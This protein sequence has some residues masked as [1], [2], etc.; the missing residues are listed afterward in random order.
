MKILRQRLGKPLLT[1]A[2]IGVLAGAAW[3]SWGL[4]KT[5]P[6]AQR[7]RIKVQAPL[8]SVAPLHRTDEPVSIAAHGTVMAARE[9]TLRSEVRGR[10]IEAH[11]QLVPGGLIRK[12]EV[13]VRIDPSDFEIAERRAKAAAAE[14]EVEWQIEQ[15]R[16]IVAQRE[17]ELLKGEDSDPGESSLALRKPQ[18]QKVEAA[19]EK[20]KADL[21]DAKL[22]LSRTVVRAPFDAVVIRE[23]V[24]TGQLIE[25]QTAI[26]ELAGTDEFW[27]EAL[28]PVGRLERI[29]IPGPEAEQQGAAVELQL[30]TGATPVVRSGTV[31]RQLAGLDPNGRMA[32]VVISVDDPLNLQGNARL[33]RLPLGSYVSL[34]I[35]AGV[36]E[37]I[38]A[39]P[40][41]ALRENN[42][43]WTVDQEKRLHIRPV[44]V[45][46]RRNDDV[47]VRTAFPT[48]E[49]AITSHLSSVIPGMP[50]RIAPSQPILTDRESEERKQV[51]AKT[52]QERGKP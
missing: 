25:T 1:L 10:V 39:V 47:L 31:C 26:A 50:V 52:L 23:S 14:A 45:I 48:G 43:V 41:F 7:E 49:Q 32:R 20:A 42:Q 8:V 34:E 3:I 30:D 36:F 6:K 17:W 11:P 22:A 12:G 16:Q 46:W 19:R 37:E 13:V 28:V 35:E 21:D 29:A 24:E 27:V 9:L 44:E 18:L 4:L 51:S 33:S 2:G 15:G 38:I 40:R 5:P